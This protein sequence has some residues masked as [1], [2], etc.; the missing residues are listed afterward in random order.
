[1]FKI[2]D[3]SFDSPIALAPMEDVSN[4]PFRQICKERGAD[5]VYTE[6]TN[7]EALSRNVQQSIDKIQ[8]TE[9]ER[10]V[11]IQLYGSNGDSLEKAATITELYAPDFIDINCGCWVK[12][13]AGRGD[14]AG[15]LRDLGKF[16][17]VVQSVMKGTRLP[18]TVKTRLGW[19]DESI[20]I[21]DVARMLVDNGV[22]ALTVHCRTRKQGYTGDA[23]WSW[24]PKIKSVAPD[25]PLIANGDIVT[26]EVVKAILDMGC[27]GA[28]IGRG[29]ISNPWIFEQTKHFL[30]TGEHLPKPTAGDRIDLCLRH[31]ADD[32]AYKDCEERRA[33][34]SFRKFYT[35]Y[36]NGLRDSKRVRVSLMA[37]EEVA[38]IRVILLGYKEEL[39]AESEST[40]V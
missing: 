33:V 1:M 10:P 22:Q 2:G 8:I 34:T 18:V 28:M 23:D 13:V 37:F 17:M 27:D 19:D 14:G 24:L 16:E 12:K 9:E 38:P 40:L 30:A 7:C 26:P 11:A 5:I 29:A 6:F 32:V 20:V 36:L 31:L 21:E 4:I 39:S 35:H 15:L 25:L 3:I